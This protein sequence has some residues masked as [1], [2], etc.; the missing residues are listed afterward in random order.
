M[1]QCVYLLYSSNKLPTINAR[2]KGIKGFKILY[3]DLKGFNASIPKT[4]DFWEL[5]NICEKP[6][7][8]SKMLVSADCG[9]IAFFQHLANFLGKSMKDL[10]N[11]MH[12]KSHGNENERCLT[13]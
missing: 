9:P 2:H 3:R 6:T 13:I 8:R 11:L 12:I 4:N 7:V 10:S 5:N 1:L